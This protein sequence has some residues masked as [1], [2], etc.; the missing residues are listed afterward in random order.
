MTP[1]CNGSHVRRLDRTGGRGT[2]HSQKGFPVH[3]THGRH[4]RARSASAAALT[5]MAG[6]SAAGPQE[7]PSAHVHAVA[8]NPADGEVYLA[9]H[10][11]LFVAGAGNERVGPV[12]DL[13]GF[14]VAGPD[15][16]YASGHPGPGTDLPQPVGLIESTDGGNTWTAISRGGESDFHTLTASTAGVAG[17][18]GVVRTSVDGHT[19]VDSSDPPAAPFDL[20]AAPDGEV[21]LATTERGPVRTDDGGATWSPVEAAPLLLLVEW[22]DE[23]TAVGLTPTGE[24]MVS[25]DRAA[26]WEQVGDLAPGAADLAPGAETQP[27]ALGAQFSSSGDLRILAVTGSAVLESVDGGAT[28]APMGN[29]GG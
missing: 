4:H 10:D 22:A 24:V 14:T 9:T 6:C 19:W 23:R 25:S 26:T 20:A 16:F 13:M 21:L 15:H 28:F 27:Q 29:G 1:P 2:P 11:G 12:I 18:D 17:F 7:L 5:L 8:V 3:V